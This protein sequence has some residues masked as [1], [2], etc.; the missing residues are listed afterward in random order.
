MTPQ[1]IRNSDGISNIVYPNRY[2]TWVSLP[3]SKH[4]RYINLVEK[5]EEWCV[6]LLGQVAKGECS[7]DRAVN[8]MQVKF[9]KLQD[10]VLNW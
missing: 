1:V 6:A 7:R 2:R 9:K 8:N 5:T 4:L 3:I 10:E